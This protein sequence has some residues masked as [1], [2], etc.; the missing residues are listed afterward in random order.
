MSKKTLFL[1]RSSWF[2]F[3]NLSLAVGKAL[4]FYNSVAKRSRAKVRN[5]LR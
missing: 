4:A 3:N 2:K 1:E 5:F